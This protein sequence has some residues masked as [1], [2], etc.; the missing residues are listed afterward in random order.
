MSPAE[1]CLEGYGPARLF[2]AHARRAMSSGVYVCGCRGVRTCLLCEGRRGNLARTD[3]TA[4]DSNSL[5]QCHNCGEVLPL[6]DCPE[7]LSLP[8]LHACRES[9]TAA[10]VLCSS[11]LM[12]QQTYAPV[13]GVT[14]VKEFISPQEEAAIL[15]DIDSQH[16]ADSQSGRRKQV[17]NRALT[18]THTHTHT[19]NTHT[20]P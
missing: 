16:W 6:R 5:Y 8:P 13:E 9:C 20:P 11:S 10:S 2:N 19:H 4:S 15:A 1:P 18:C 17:R 3:D 7:D 12:Q 14:V